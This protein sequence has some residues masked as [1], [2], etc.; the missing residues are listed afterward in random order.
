MVHVHEL[1]LNGQVMVSNGQNRNAIFEFLCGLRVLIELIGILFLASRLPSM[2][3]VI[4]KQGRLHDYDCLVRVKHGMI[5]PAKLR[6]DSAHVQMSVSL[7]SGRL[8][9][10]FDLQGLLQEDQSRTQL[11]YLAVVAG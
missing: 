8:M 3:Q 4:H 1:L 11:I 10:L 5:V 9:P 6:Q 2:W 7:C